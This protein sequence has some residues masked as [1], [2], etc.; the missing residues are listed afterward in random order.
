MAWI[1]VMMGLYSS[2][3]KAGP[4]TWGGVQLFLCYLGKL[5]Q[6]CDMF[7]FFLPETS[8]V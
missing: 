8:W 2:R 7:L 5:F 4:Y 3:D 1:N 6:N